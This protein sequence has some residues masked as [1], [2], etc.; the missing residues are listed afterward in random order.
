[1][2][3]LFWAFFIVLSL[4]STQSEASCAWQPYPT[5]GMGCRCVDGSWANYIGGQLQCPQPVPPPHQPEPV[6]QHCK[7]GGKALDVGRDEPI[8]GRYVE[9]GEDGTD[10][11]YVKILK[12]LNLDWQIYYYV[13]D[14]FRNSAASK[15]EDGDRFIVIDSNWNSEVNRVLWTFIVLHE[16]GH[17][18][19]GHVDNYVDRNQ[20]ASVEDELQADR[21]AGWAVKQLGLGWSLSR[22]IDELRPFYAGGAD[23]SHSAKNDRLFAIAQGWNHGRPSGCSG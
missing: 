5:G 19:C 13:S 11:P 9:L 15:D 16:L 7:D 20:R 2:R 10:P 21:F 12:R 14:N 4:G 18:V 22:V 17:H 3:K 23:G 6:E 1:M 8:C